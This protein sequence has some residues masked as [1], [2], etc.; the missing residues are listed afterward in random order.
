M[1]RTLSVLVV[2]VLTTACQPGDVPDAGIPVV[3]L[4]RGEALPVGSESDTSTVDT[5]VATTAAEASSLTMERLDPDTREVV[6][7][8]DWL[9]GHMFVL[10]TL[11]QG[12]S[13]AGLGVDEVFV[14]GSAQEAEDGALQLTYVLTKP[15]IVAAARSLQYVGILVPLHPDVRATLVVE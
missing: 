4:F 10:G 11:V 15:E 13:Y 2:T 7:E 5:Y 1:P 9:E 3:E 14:V 6:T 12:S 8:A